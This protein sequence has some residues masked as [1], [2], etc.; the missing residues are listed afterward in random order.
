MAGCIELSECIGAL[1]TMS[2]TLHSATLQ[3]DEVSMSC[4]SAG[5]WQPPLLPCRALSKR[6]TGVS[7]TGGDL[8]AIAIRNEAVLNAC[9]GFQGSIWLMPGEPGYQS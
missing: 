9:H 8:S 4:W 5:S 3:T 1:L 7:L 6:S 2:R